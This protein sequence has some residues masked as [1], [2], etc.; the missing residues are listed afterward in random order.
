MDAAQA[1]KASLA[2][3]QAPPLGH[4]DAAL[5][6]DHR[7]RHGAAAVDQHADLAAEVGRE[8]GQL[9]R[10]FLGDE[11]IGWEAAPVEALEGVNLAG[12]EALCVAEDLDGSLSGALGLGSARAHAE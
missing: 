1:A 8:F 10:E 9:A 4:L 11:A 2:G 7:V 3:A 6:A 12:L 5:G